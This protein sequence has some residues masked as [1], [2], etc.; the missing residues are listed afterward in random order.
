M[1][2]VIVRH[3]RENLKKCSLRGL[4]KRDDLRFY[5]YPIQ[6]LPD[7]TGAI[8]LKV[9]APPLT[10]EDQ[11]RTILL[12]DGTWRLAAIMEH[13][14]PPLETRSLPTHF[15]TAYPRTPNPEGGLASVEALYIAHRIL[16]RS[17]EGLLDHYYWKERF[18]T[19]N[20]RVW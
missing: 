17:T 14:L 7:L 8:L 20:Q 13:Q 6:Q 2:T 10:I 9:G 12:I 18:L 16:G 1:K 3:R 11:E 5:T 15:Q 19:L 4:E